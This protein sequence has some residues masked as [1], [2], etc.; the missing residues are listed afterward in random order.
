M[1]TFLNITLKK[2]NVDEE[3]V[4]V[5]VWSKSRMYSR[6][7][8]VFVNILF[9]IL[10]LV[11]LIIGVVTLISLDHNYSIFREH[12]ISPVALVLAF[13]AFLFFTSLCAL[14]SALC[15]SNVLLSVYIC[16]LGIL[17]VTELSVVIAGFVTK[18]HLLRAVS[19]TLRS[20]E[21][22]YANDG[23][24]NATWDFIQRDLE[25]CGVENYKEW[26]IYL[27]NFSIPDSCCVI[28]SFGC[29]SAVTQP[30][31]FYQS[32]CA[33]MIS[34]WADTQ[35]ITVAVLYSCMVTLQLS[36]LLCLK[37]YLQVPQR[38]DS[39]SADL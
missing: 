15:R 13:S 3:S 17:I 24:V 32:G 7:C 39:F 8:L 9:I 4:E 37:R 20:A 28:Y 31:N 14:L 33:Q 19:N 30:E 36:C 34:E 21:P 12:L 5:Y 18:P 16:T 27:G 38:Y 26:F 10:S 2:K 25:C 35:E 23:F 11:L 1:Y 29:G 22:S 6:H